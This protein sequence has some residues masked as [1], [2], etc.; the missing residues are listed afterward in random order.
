M[1]LSGIT[2]KKLKPGKAKRQVEDDYESQSTSSTEV[3]I[4]TPYHQSVPECAPNPGG[5]STQI[6]ILFIYMTFCVWLTICWSVSRA[7][8]IRRETGVFYE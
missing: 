3:E 4:G 1:R 5:I 8:K 6:S 7:K 2:F